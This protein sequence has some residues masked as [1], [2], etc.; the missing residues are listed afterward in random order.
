MTTEIEN[1]SI[2]DH[3]FVQ[4]IQRIKTQMPPGTNIV[5]S[6]LARLQALWDMAGL[7]EVADRLIT[8]PG[9]RALNYGDHNAPA[10]VGLG[11]VIAYDIWYLFDAGNVLEFGG[12]TI[13]D[14]MAKLDSFFSEV[15]DAKPLKLPE[16]PPTPGTYTLGGGG[17]TMMGPAD[18]LGSKEYVIKEARFETFETGNSEMY[19]S[20]GPKQRQSSYA[21]YI[22]F[23]MGPLG[24]MWG[25][26]LVTQSAMAGASGSV[27]PV[28]YQNATQQGGEL[29]P[30]FDVQRGEVAGEKLLSKGYLVEDDTKTEIIAS[31]FDG[32]DNPALHQW[33][34][35]WI[36]EDNTEIVPGEFVAVL[37]R[38][39]PLHCWWYQE[40]SPFVYAGNW[41][42]TEFYTS[43]IVQE[44]QVI[45]ED[46]TPESGEV[47]N[48]YKVW[49]KN[50]EIIVKSSDFYEYE[51]NEQVGLLKTY[52]DSADESYDMSMGPAGQSGQTTNFNWQHLELQ[53]TGDSLNT[54]WVIVPASFY[55]SSGSVGGT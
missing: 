52:R 53:D 2:F 18:A 38:P 43:G 44:V 30:P 23:P 5:G 10:R 28:D 39:W 37:C 35:Y 36:T 34:R 26:S 51:V 11:L 9:D 31:T 4:Y 6:L 50:E 15:D 25:I 1:E 12:K 48:R 21:G 42:E 8:A 7:G 14:T 45:D 27:K 41:I 55:E 49:V 32:I 40:T 24:V 16:S 46:F 54:T 3:P 47:G 19:A 17:G 22:A 13:T 33:M 20:T 29:L